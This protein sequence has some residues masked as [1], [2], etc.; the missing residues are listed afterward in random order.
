MFNTI[1]LM[2]ILLNFVIITIVFWLITLLELYLN[3]NT[4]NNIKT[5]IYECGFLTINKNIFQLN[6]NTIILL[7]FVIIYEVEFI[8]L[9]PIFLSLSWATT[10]TILLIC[11]LFVVIVVTLYLDIWLNKLTW[12]Y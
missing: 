11:I 5:T 6:Y 1:I 10:N 2:F 9:I 7:L 4:N 8:I 12:V 3:K